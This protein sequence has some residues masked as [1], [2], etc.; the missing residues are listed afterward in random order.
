[1]KLR[2]YVDKPERAWRDTRDTCRRWHRGAGDGGALILAPCESLIQPQ[3]CRSTD[4]NMKVENDKQ[5]NWALPARSRMIPTRRTNLNIS[6]STSTIRA[7]AARRPQS[8]QVENTSE[9]T[10]S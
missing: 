10:G 4:L 2:E 9:R 1:M 3:H 8:L 7:P 6:N 5:T